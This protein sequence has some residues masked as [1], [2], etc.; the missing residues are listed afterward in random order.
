MD[1]HELRTCGQCQPWT[2]LSLDRYPGRTLIRL[3]NVEFKTIIHC[4]SRNKEGNSI[5]Q[6]CFNLQVELK[7]TS[8][9]NVTVLAI[10]DSW[11]ARSGDRPV[12]IG[13][14]ISKFCWSWSGPRF[15]NF[16]WSWSSP[17]PAFKKFSRFWSDSVLGSVPG[18]F[19]DPG[20]LLVI[21]D[22]GSLRLSRSWSELVLDI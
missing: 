16:W 9:S 4:Q 11:T 6:I 8:R 14:I 5:S 10:R 22:P 20:P 19:L 7:C 17:V 12:R 21:N 2:G 15:G 3:K 13:P 1:S 18:N